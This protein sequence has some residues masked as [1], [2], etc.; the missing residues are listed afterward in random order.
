MSS[1][2]KDS[3]AHWTAYWQF[4]SAA[5]GSQ[6]PVLDL[7]I[8]PVWFEFTDIMAD[9]ARILDV[10]TGN[11]PV[12]LSCA[13]RA[14]ACQRHIHIDAVDAAEIRPPGQAQGSGDQSTQVSG[15]KTCPLKTVS[16]TLS[17]LNTD[18][19]MPMSHKLSAKFHVFSLPAA[20]CG[21]SS[22]RGTVPSGRI[23]MTE[24]NV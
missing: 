13:A 10:A 6:R 19:N 18:L 2:G 3:I 21:W 16:S 20:A 1:L 11:G 24:L 9:G 15:W 12:A 14:S 23:S 4:E 22:M 5:G 7:I 17:C 8:E